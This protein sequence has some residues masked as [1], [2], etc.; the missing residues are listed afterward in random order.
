MYKTVDI[1]KLCDIIGLYLNGYT[2]KELQIIGYTSAQYH[3]T[4]LKLTR[5]KS[6]S[7]KL[8]WKK[9]NNGERKIIIIRS[10]PDW[11]KFPHPRGMLGKHHTDEVKR[12]ISRRGENHPMWHG[13]SSQNRFRG[14]DWPSIRLDIY[15]RDGYR[16]QICHSNRNLVCHHIVPYRL[17]K[18]NDYNNLIT[19]CKSCHPTYEN[20]P[21]KLEVI[22]GR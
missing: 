18:N 22:N 14:Y 15:K 3:L 21:D 2:M 4:K 10:L 19:L 1:V 11:N 20:K 6:L 17:T 16:C 8:G 13:G 5:N 7:A 12:K 9:D